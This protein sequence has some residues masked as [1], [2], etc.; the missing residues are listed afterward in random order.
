MEKVRLGDVCE[1]QSGGTP[2]RSNP[3]FWDNGKIPWVKI[4][5]FNG[6]YLNKT[7]ECITQKAL[8]NSSAKMFD[9][10]TILYTIF[11]TLG[12]ICILDIQ[13][14]TNQAIAGIKIKDGRIVKDYLY[15]FGLSENDIEQAFS[16]RKI[17]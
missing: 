1:I 9:E 5:D 3:D 8:E 7:Q 11:A 12:E 14:A 6:K 13:A 2:S 16:I 15:N 10:G 17:K 4:S